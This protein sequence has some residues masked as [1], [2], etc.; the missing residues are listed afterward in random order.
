MWARIVECMLGCWLLMSPFIFQHSEKEIALWVN[1]LSVG[2][3]LIVGSLASYWKRTF[4]A[5]WLFL[6]IGLWLIGFGRFSYS[7]PLPRGYQNEIITGILLLMF[8]IVPNE[9][10]QPPKSW[11]NA[12]GRPG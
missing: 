6:P 11:Q 7:P 2:I 4:W 9:A 3:V 10:T 8:A 12:D 1:D 5:H